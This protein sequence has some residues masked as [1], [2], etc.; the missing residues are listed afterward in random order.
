M[1]EKVRPLA[2]KP[3]PFP[4]SPG[5]TQLLVRVAAVAV[6][7]IE[8]IKQDLGGLLYGWVKFP[9]VLGSDV[10]GTVVEVGSDE[11]TTGRFR[12]GDRVLGHALGSEKKFNDAAMGAF[13][14]YVL[15]QANM[16][17]PIPDS[18]SFERAAVLPLALSTASCGLFQKDQ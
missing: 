9:H 1:G 14:H 11:R 17:S 7:P 4:S 13:Q 6:N 15:L 2:V 8:H 12:P 5:S 3:A 18:L 10:A 16:V